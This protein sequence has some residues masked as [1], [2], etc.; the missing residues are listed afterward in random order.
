MSW[1]TKVLFP[2]EAKGTVLRLDA[3]ISFWGGIDPET[4]EVILS[5]HPQVGLTISEKLLVIPEPIGSSSSAAIILELLFAGLAPN[6]LILGTSRD[7][8]LPVGVLVA[9]QMN[10]A[11]IPILAMQNPPF[12][13]GETLEILE[14]GVVQVL[15]L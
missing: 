14:N 10:W 11:T 6:A 3:P 7:A 13:T 12:K 1:S 2:G 5:Q 15:S 9:E 8:I 4:S